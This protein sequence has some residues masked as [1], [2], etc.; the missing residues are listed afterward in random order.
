MS[1][2][3]TR[4][5]LTFSR[6]ELRDLAAAWIILSVAFAI[7]MFRWLAQTFGL[8]A[9]LGVVGLSLVTVGV[10]FMLHELAHKIV[11]IHFG[12]I[13]E[14]RADYQ[15]LVLAV[16]SAFLGFLFAAPGAVHHRGRI[17][18][19]QN[20]L[21]ALA[22][23]ATNLG[24][25]VLFAPMVLLPG[26]GGLIGV[27]GVW[28]NLFLAAFNMIPYGPL[29]GKS[30]IEWNKLVFALVFAPSAVLAAISTLV[31]LAVI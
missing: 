5:G 8:E 6:V 4:S 16:L 21:I 9:F 28:I 19:R 7:L 27:M 13:A 1:V 30:V 3:R 25:A 14:F 2:R 23:P 22:G 26:F 31:V 12:Q 15:M 24:L 17:T 29:D 10:A 11:A 18:P 20:G